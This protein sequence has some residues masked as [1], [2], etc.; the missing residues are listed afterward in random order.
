MKD[1]IPVSGDERIT[2]TLDEKDTA[3]GFIRDANQPGILTWSLMLP[4]SGKHEIV[5]HYRVRAPRGLP[6]TGME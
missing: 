1:R 3:A 4:K 5:L 6:L 2:V